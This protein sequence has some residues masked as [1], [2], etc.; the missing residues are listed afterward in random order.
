MLTGSMPYP[1]LTHLPGGGT[2][3]ALKNIGEQSGNPLR[4]LGLRGHHEVVVVQMAGS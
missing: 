1:R 4:L 3:D 2:E